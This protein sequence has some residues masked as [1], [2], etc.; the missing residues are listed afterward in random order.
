MFYNFWAL[1]TV[2]LALLISYFIFKHELQRK[3]ISF[4]QLLIWTVTLI[5]LVIGL[6]NLSN[7]KVLGS[8]LSYAILSNLYMA[9][10]N[11]GVKLQKRIS[12][13]I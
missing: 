12:K 1:I 2:V 4:A 3:I 10:I 9:I 8:M 5:V 11:I 6:S 13:N 7:M